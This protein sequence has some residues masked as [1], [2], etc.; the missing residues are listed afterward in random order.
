[1][2]QLSLVEGIQLSI[3]LCKAQFKEMEMCRRSATIHIRRDWEC[4]QIMIDLLLFKGWDNW[5]ILSAWYSTNDL[6]P[7]H[8]IS[9]EMNGNTSEE[10][11][12]AIIEDN[13]STGKV[14]ASEASPKS[15]GKKIFTHIGFTADD[16]TERIYCCPY[17]DFRTP[18]KSKVV[19]H[20]KNYH[21]V[22]PSND[23][24]MENS[25]CLMS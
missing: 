19:R 10:E 11:I 16:L 1:M 25:I 12:I 17:C 14:T 22:S 13:R 7:I 15:I 6:V 8:W 4:L 2:H 18:R 21:N 23:E 3:I 5:D 24:V 20:Y 9:Y